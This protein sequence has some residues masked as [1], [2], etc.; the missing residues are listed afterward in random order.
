[1]TDTTITLYDILTKLS[2]ADYKKWCK[3]QRDAK[4]LDF[5]LNFLVK[6]VQNFTQQP[7]LFKTVKDIDLLLTPDGYL[8]Y[9]DNDNDYSMAVGQTIF[10]IFDKNDITTYFPSLDYKTLNNDAKYNYALLQKGDPFTLAIHFRYLLPK[11]DKT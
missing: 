7:D 2:F 8:T 1:M 10:D 5:R 3:A 11:T 6:K 9:G 4:T